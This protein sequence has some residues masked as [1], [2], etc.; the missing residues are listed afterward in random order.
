M[1]HKLRIMVIDDDPNTCLL[2][3]ELFNIINQQYPDIELI[4]N[5]SNKAEKII[6]QKSYRQC[7]ILICD[8]YFEHSYGPEIIHKIKLDPQQKIKIFVGISNDDVVDFTGA[9]YFV[10]KAKL[11]NINDFKRIFDVLLHKMT[12]K[13]LHV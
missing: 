12:L 13:T 9:D 4:Y 6:S 5:S 3:H 2:Y 7:D 1:K 8:Y 10:P 11:I